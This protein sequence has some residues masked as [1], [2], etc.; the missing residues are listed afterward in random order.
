MA[1]LCGVLFDRAAARDTLARRQFGLVFDGI[2]QQIEG[3]LRMGLDKLKLRKCQSEGLDVATILHLVKAVGWS[4]LVIGCGHTAR[5]R[6]SMVINRQQHVHRASYGD[7]RPADTA[8]GTE[9]CKIFGDV[10]YGQSFDEG[11]I[12]EPRAVGVVSRVQSFLP[13]AHG[14]FPEPEVMKLP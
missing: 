4:F 3:V 10:G 9:I 5:V 8:G 7:K 12:A 1:R 13:L 6:A 11:V 2:H 14:E